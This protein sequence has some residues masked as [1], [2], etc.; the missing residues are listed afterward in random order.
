M[1][2][3]APLNDDLWIDFFVPTY[4]QLHRVRRQNSLKGVDCSTVN[5]AGPCDSA[6]LV[7]TPLHPHP[8]GSA[9]LTSSTALRPFHGIQ[10]TVWRMN[11]G[12]GATAIAERKRRL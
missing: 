5:S 1:L 4:V 7:A 8:L 2:R 6:N 11:I 9:K 3:R 10:D 12:T